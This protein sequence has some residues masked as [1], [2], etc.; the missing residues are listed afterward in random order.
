MSC[1]DLV[2]HF[3]ELEWVKVLEIS[4]P[5]DLGWLVL[6]NMLRPAQF[7]RIDL[8]SWLSERVDAN[9]AAA[10]GSRPAQLPTTV[11]SRF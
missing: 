5:P 9:C 11:S 7:V 10:S 1:G 4:V 3:K 2:M 8:G 6:I